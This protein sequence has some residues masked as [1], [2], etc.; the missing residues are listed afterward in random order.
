MEAKAKA[1]ASTVAV[2]GG[3]VGAGL[4]TAMVAVSEK[5]AV[6]KAWQKVAIVIGITSAASVSMA[7]LA[8]VAYSTL[9]K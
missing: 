1:V 2:I 9:T 5:I 4:G 7:G 8:Y 6:L 3:V